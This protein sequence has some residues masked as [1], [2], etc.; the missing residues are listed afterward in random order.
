MHGEPKQARSATTALIYLTVGALTVVWT[1]IAYI[2]LHYNEGTFNQYL[3]CHGFFLTGIV[4]MVIGLALGRIG[5]AARA[6]EVTGPPPVQTVQQ[7][8]PPAAQPVSQPAAPAP[9]SYGQPVVTAPQAAPPP[10]A[11]AQSAQPLTRY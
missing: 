6:A 3:W 9:N 8:L 7:V 5:R 11:P 4:L 10:P 1:I 2:W